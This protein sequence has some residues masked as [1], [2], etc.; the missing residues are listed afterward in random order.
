[1]FFSGTQ[2]VPSKRVEF[3]AK[4]EVVFLGETGEREFLFFSKL[5]TLEVASISCWPARDLQLGLGDLFGLWKVVRVWVLK[6][7]FSRIAGL[8]AIIVC[9][10]YLFVTACIE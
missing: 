9:P 1:M 4:P 7:Y 2:E 5:S 8:V 6:T 10:P 3:I